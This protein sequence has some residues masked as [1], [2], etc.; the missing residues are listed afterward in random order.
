MSKVGVC[1]PYRLPKKIS[2]TCNQ[3]AT[4]DHFSSATLCRV[5]RVF[6]H[7]S[8]TVIVLPRVSPQSSISYV[9][10]QSSKTFS[11]APQALFLV[12]AVILPQFCHHHRFQGSPPFFTRASAKTHL[13]DKKIPI[14]T[15]SEFLSEK[16]L[17]ERLRD[18]VDG[19]TS[20]RLR[21]DALGT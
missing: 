13:F 3:S 10:K 18:L 20:Q 17:T 1:L 15:N 7:N 12:S 14:G 19:Y 4:K 16:F 2:Y 8:A 11:L 9:I 6:C 21:L 5:S